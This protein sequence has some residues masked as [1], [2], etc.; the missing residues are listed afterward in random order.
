MGVVVN[1]QCK[2]VDHGEGSGDLRGEDAAFRL[3][4]AVES[5]ERILI[6][7]RGIPVAQLVAPPADGRRQATGRRERIQKALAALERS[8]KATSLDVPLRDAIDEGRD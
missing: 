3:I 2:I 8:R 6:T 5:G 4:S 1:Q 7:R